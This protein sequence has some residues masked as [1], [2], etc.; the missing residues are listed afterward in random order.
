MISHEKKFIFVHIPRTGGTALSK[1][2]RPYCDEESLD[3]SPFPGEDANLHATIREYIAEYGRDILEKYTIF[4]IARNPWERALSHSIH[5][6]DGKFDREK[7]REH[8]FRPHE[9]GYWPHSHF[10]FFIPFSVGKMPDG[11][12]A[13]PLSYPAQHTMAAVRDL[14]QHIFFPHFIRFENYASDISK[15][16]DKLGIEHS[17]EDLRRK[18]NYTAHKH[19]SHYYQDDEIK[20]IRNVCGFDLQIFGYTFEDRREK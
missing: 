20:E 13:L 16:F 14:R 5:H 4:S 19:Y 17:M 1:F 7:F 12:E 9:N 11:R 18:S 15:L 2:L 10:H 8:V 3:F 6:N